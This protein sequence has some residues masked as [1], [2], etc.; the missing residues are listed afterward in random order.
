M[1][2]QSIMTVQNFVDR[3]FRPEHVR[4]KK[5]AGQRHY[6]T[7]FK[8]VLPALG[9]MRLCDVRLGEVQRLLSDKLNERYSLGKESQRAGTYS[10]QTVRHIRNAISAIFEHAKRRGIYSGEN[11]AHHAKLPEMQ[12]RELHALSW[13][14]ME[15]LLE[16]LPSPARE[17]SLFAVLT[18]MNIAELCGLQWKCVN[19][20]ESWVTVGGEAL[21]PRTIAVRRQWY[22]NAY[23]TVK[24][25]RRRRILPISARMAEEFRRIREHSRFTGPDDPVFASKTGRPMDEHNVAKR[26]L[27]KIGAQLG[28]TW[29]SWHCFR[30]THTTLADQLEMTA[31]DRM[32]MM[33][34][35]D[36]RMTERYTIV[37]LDRRREVVERM[38][39]R[40][41]GNNVVEIKRKAG[42]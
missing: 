29:L 1:C 16:N 8:H 27:K 26:T 25:N 30:R 9:K 42:A 31:G 4:M 37:D 22:R 19:L 10:V 21:P 3:Y 28:M 2:P 20:T 5:P 38:A 40:L 35:A 13:A 36:M 18:S 6:E 41:L 23:G 14:Q 12:R 39:E 32:A 7:M 33:G 15:A 24:A 17:V 11:P 34:H